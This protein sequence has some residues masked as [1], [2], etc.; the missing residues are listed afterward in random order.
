MALPMIH[1]LAAYEWAQ[2][3]PEYASCPEYYLGTISPDAMHIRDGN[4]KSRKNEFHLNNWRTPDPDAVVEYWRAH[5][6]PFDVGYGIHV[7]LDGHWATGFR[8]DFPGLL[9]PSGRPDPEIYYN[10]TFTAD[11]RLYHE[12]SRT[13]FFLEMLRRAEAPDDHPLL[14]QSEIEGWKQWTFDFY[15]NKKP[16]GKPV[17][18]IDTEYIERFLRICPAIFN[19]VYERMEEK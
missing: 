14:T 10:D 9:L 2:D 4:D 19:E 15:K 7:L 6:T 8:R 1:L 18:F 3:K 5:F 11:Y 13:D 12:S 17:R 16:T